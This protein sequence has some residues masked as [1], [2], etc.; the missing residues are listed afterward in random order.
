MAEAGFTVIRVGESVWSTWEPEDGVLDLDWLEPVLDEAHERGIGVILG[1]PTYA[2]PMWLKRR[3]PEIAGDSATGQPIGWG[4]RQEVDFTHAAYLFHAERII[5]AVVTR[6]R[7]HPG[8]HRL[9]GRQRARPA[10]APQRERLPAVRRLA[11]SA[12]RHGRASQRGVGPRLLV[13]PAL[14]LGGPVA[15]RRQLPAAVRP[16]LAP[17][18]D[19]AGH[20]VHRLAGRHRARPR[21]PLALRDHLHLLR[22]ARHRGRRPVRATRHRLRQ[23]LLRDGVLARAPQRLADVCRTD[24]LGRPWAVGRLAARRPHVLLASGALPRH[25]D[26]RRLD[27][28]LVVEPVAVRRPVAAG[29]LAPGRPWRAD[30]LLL[31]LEHPGLRRRDLLGRRPA[32]QRRARPRLPRA[33]RPRRRARAAPATPSRTPSRTSTSPSSTTPTA[34]WP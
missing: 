2:I 22:T 11:A 23:R 19:R 15:A 26:Q 30:D 3:Y 27:R 17:L 31:A 16:R 12:L 18:P 34:S 29:G 13:A 33:L 25:R 21:G 28:L 5:R 20:R 4:A 24:G 9:P 1:T 14:D 10:T 7:E 6:Y 8:D 32:A